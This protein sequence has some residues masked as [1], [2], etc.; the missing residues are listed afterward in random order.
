V[1]S[2]GRQ[3]ED[4]DEGS[5]FSSDS[6]NSSSDLSDS[7]RREFFLSNDTTD[8]SRIRQKLSL[9]HRAMQN[10]NLISH[11][12]RLSN[13][14]RAASGEARAAK[15]S[16]WWS[17]MNSLS[18]STTPQNQDDQVRNASSYVQDVQAFESYAKTL[19][20][21]RFPDSEPWLHTRVLNSM[22]YRRVRCLYLMAKKNS[23][24]S[25]RLNVQ[26]PGPGVLAAPKPVA[27]VP[28]PPR[29]TAVKFESDSQA[30]IKPTSNV[31]RVNKND[32]RKPS[33]TIVSTKTS[34]S[35]AD[36]EMISIP[37]CPENPSSNKDF[38]CPYCNFILPSSEAL[39][40]KWKY[41]YCPIPKW[42]SEC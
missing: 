8:Q 26:E 24:A 10:D 22:K 36:D 2:A 38:T 18:T 27:E 12:Q 14:V 1:E 41:V 25:V 3:D 39:P 5:A 15:V 4:A 32:F 28:Q 11:L 33:T 40:S 21:C 6:S 31:S 17:R 7:A 9:S 19:L 23:S 34:F 29:R 13:S 30:V 42:L 35:S 37:P 16:A 20:K